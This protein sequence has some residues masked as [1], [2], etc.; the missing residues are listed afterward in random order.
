MV[1]GDTF[2]NLVETFIHEGI[3]LV[4]MFTVVYWCVMLGGGGSFF[5]TETNIFSS[6]SVSF[7]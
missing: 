2:K 4:E 3:L 6:Y 7:K 5:P 1:S